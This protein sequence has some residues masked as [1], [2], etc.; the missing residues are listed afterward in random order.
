MPQA[1]LKEFKNLRDFM[2]RY[3]FH[4]KEAIGS[5]QWYPLADLAVRQE[6]EGKLE[7]LAS[8]EPV[9]VLYGSG[10]SFFLLT[11]E[12]I[13]KQQDGEMILLYHSEVADDQHTFI[14]TQ[15]QPCFHL[16]GKMAWSYY[17][18]CGLKS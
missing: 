2:W 16:L 3:V 18:T 4:E 1:K 8:E 9:S 13:I 12:R 10:A 6:I 14:D 15:R 5:F 11:T 17:F 7:F